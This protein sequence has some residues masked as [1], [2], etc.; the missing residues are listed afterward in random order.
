MALPRDSI[1]C[2][3]T[4]APSAH[5]HRPNAH[6]NG[7]KSLMDPMFAITFKEIKCKFHGENRIGKNA[8]MVLSDSRLFFEDLDLEDETLICQDG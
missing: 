5:T 6:T 2:A 1:Q 3:H 4:N 8:S 7:S